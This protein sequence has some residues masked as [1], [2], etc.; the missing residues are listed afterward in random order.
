MKGG[1]LTIELGS[2]RFGQPIDFLLKLKETCEVQHENF[3]DVSINYF[4]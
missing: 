3:F 4:S 2:I 1:S